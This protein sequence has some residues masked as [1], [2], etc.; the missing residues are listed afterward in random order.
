MLTLNF[1][2]NEVIFTYNEYRNGLI[3]NGNNIYSLHSR[4]SDDDICNLCKNIINNP[5]IIDS[6]E[7]V[8]LCEKCYIRILSMA[9]ILHNFR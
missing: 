8:I 4:L 2:G 3:V 1:N 5:K 6:K 9:K 7:T